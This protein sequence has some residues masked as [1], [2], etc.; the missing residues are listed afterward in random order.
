[1]KKA[2][3]MEGVAAI[4]NGNFWGTQRSDAEI[5]V[6][7]FGDFEHARICDPK[8]CIEPTDMTWNPVNRGGYNHEYEELKKATLVKVR[9]T[10]TIE[11]EVL[12]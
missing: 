10:V 9:K 3:V 4:Y 6:N 1:M 5:T 12:E 11:F 7:G 2:K 8:F